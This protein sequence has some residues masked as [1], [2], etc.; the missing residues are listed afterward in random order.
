MT[1]HV[2]RPGTVPRQYRAARG[3]DLCSSL[4][5]WLNG[6]LSSSA[7]HCLV[8]GYPA[9]RARWHTTS[10]RRRCNQRKQ[11]QAHAHRTK[12]LAQAEHGIALLLHAMIAGSPQRAMRLARHRKWS[13]GRS[14]SCTPTILPRPPR[15]PSLWAGRCASA[16]NPARRA[17]IPTRQWTPRSCTRRARV[18]PGTAP[19]IP[20]LFQAGPGRFLRL[21]RRRV[22]KPGIGAL[23]CGE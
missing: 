17:S 16:P 19:G 23:H 20:R 11:G 8:R 22:P 21:C 3:R 6:S 12:R 14:M 4:L 9:S 13:T 1:R 10:H 18:H 2:S 7:G 5:P 15:V